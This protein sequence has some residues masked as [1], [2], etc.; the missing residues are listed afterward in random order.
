MSK[1]DVILTLR[2]EDRMDEA[3]TK[4]AESDERTIAWMARKLLEEALVARG[5][6][7]AKDEA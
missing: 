3:I 6:L 1:K 2:I 4:L 7:D 5:A